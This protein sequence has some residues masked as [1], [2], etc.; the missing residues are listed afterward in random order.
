VLFQEESSRICLEKVLGRSKSLR[1]GTEKVLGWSK[2]WK[3]DTG[4]AFSNENL[5]GFFLK[6][7]FL[8]RNLDRM[9]LSD[10]FIVSA[11]LVLGFLAEKHSPFPDVKL[12][13]FFGMD[14]F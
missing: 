10:L 9:S 5:C 14:Y 11:S 7:H 3:N 12:V 2:S 4:K 8:D 6:K 13:I 1:I